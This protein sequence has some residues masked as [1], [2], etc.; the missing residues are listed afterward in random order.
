MND[1]AAVD[2]APSNP[3]RSTF[4]LVAGMLA[5]VVLSLGADEVLRT[6]AL[7]FYFL[8][9][10]LTTRFRNVVTA[11]ARPFYAFS[12]GVAVEVLLGFVLSAHVFG[13]FWRHFGE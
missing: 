2:P 1:V 8:S 9:I 10:G 6:W 12:A 3:W 7:L 11:G 5:V 4:A 13:D